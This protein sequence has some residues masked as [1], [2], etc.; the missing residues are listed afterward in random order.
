MD[1][2]ESQKLIAYMRERVLPLSDPR[3][4]GK[5]L[6]GPKLGK[7]WRYRCGSYRIIANIIDQDLVVMVVRVGNRKDVY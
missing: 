2:Y 7:Y 4:L 3:S 5:S 6:K 1:R